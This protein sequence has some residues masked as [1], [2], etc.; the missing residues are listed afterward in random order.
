M[1]RKRVFNPIVSLIVIGL[2]AQLCA[3]PR[4]A[5]TTV[6][7]MVWL[8][9]NGDGVRDPDE[10][11]MPGMEVGLVTAAD[12]NVVAQTTT[13]AAGGYTFS[14][15]E[16]HAFRV[17]FALPD[18]Y[19]FSPKDQG[20]DDSFDSDVNAGGPFPGQTD[21]F[22]PG[23]K[24]QEHWDG[25][26]VANLLVPTAVPTTPEVVPSTPLPSPKPVTDVAGDY[27]VQ[28]LVAIDTGQNASL[29]NLPPTGTMHVTQDGQNLTIEIV[30]TDPNQTR[31]T[32]NSILDAFGTTSAFASSLVAGIQDVRTQMAGGFLRVDNG[33]ITVSFTLEVGVNGEF[34]GGQEVV[35]SIVSE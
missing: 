2:G 32:F 1:E 9:A 33:A 30:G 5:P 26:L 11:G 7:G 25:G 12:S 27:S 28:F 23:E 20:Q 21:S 29:V 10:K 15:V 22:V 24:N 13:D 16:E 17:A 35:Y 31:M 3:L 34:P 4:T 14:S 6:S 8:D 18:G 19:A